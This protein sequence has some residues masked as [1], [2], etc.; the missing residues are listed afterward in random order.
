AFYNVENL[1]DLADDPKTLD[2]DFTPEGRQKWTEERYEKK[3]SRIGEVITGLEFPD[4]VGLCEV[5]NEQVLQD[6]VDHDAIKKQNY[7]FRHFDSPDR[8]G[9]DVALLYRKSEFKPIKSYPIRVDIPDE[10]E[11]DYTTRDILYV[12]GTY[13]KDHVLHLFVNH[14]PSRRGGVAASEPKRLVAARRLRSAVDSLFRMNPM[15]KIIIMG[16]FNDETD[17]KS[18]QEVLNSKLEIPKGDEKT[19]KNLAAAGDVAQKGSYNYRGNW[20]MLDQIIVSRALAPSGK[21]SGGDLLVDKQQ[22]LDADWLMFKDDK[23]GSRPNRTYG[24]PN[25]YGGYS[26]HLPVYAVMK[27]YK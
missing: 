10:V 15:S 21:I 4:F 5:E 17:N 20:N 1:F 23:Y 24:G 14:W 12:K 19:L 7:Q 6:L 18:V 13:K 26:D 3:L 2:D 22:I 8:R 16:D 11:E 25:Y 9:I 27:L